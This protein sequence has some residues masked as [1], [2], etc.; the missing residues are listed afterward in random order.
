MRTTAQ[1]DVSRCPDA[2]H[3]RGRGPGKE[4]SRA[5]R[6]REM[7]QASVVQHSVPIKLTCTAFGISQ[8]CY[9]YQPK[10]DIENEAIANWL[11]R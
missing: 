7:A 1:E 11:T 5:S 10:K 2:R 3:N 6:R 8:T 4:V 9:R